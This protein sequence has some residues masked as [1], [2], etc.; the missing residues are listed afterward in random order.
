MKV[1]RYHNI[2]ST[3]CPFGWIGTEEF[4][5]LEHAN[6]YAGTR[7]TRIAVLRV[8]WDGDKLP[9]VEVLPVR[10]SKKAALAAGE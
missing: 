8:T 2:F 7:T 3:G 1:F 5:S 10:K 6:R 4:E 9:S